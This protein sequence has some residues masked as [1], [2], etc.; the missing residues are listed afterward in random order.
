MLK[1]GLL[2]FGVFKPMDRKNFN[3]IQ[4]EQDVQQILVSCQSPL[5]DRNWLDYSD[6]A[7]EPLIL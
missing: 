3:G 6:L 5:G 4:F 7:E 1:K 2:D